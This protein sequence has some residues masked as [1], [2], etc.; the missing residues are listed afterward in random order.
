MVSTKLKK[1]NTSQYR[2]IVDSIDRDSV[3]VAEIDGKSIQSLSEYLEAVWQVFRFPNT[4]YVNYYA[5]LDWI[6]DLDWLN[7]EKYVFIVHNSADLLRETLR[8]RQIVM[9][10]LE[11]EVIP[12]WE[13][14]VEQYSVAGKAKPFHV[15]LVD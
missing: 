1:I 15:Y 8:D 6:R 5:Y 2:A 7:S 12:W 3:F 13:G 11:E 4:G 10:S 9:D 14:E